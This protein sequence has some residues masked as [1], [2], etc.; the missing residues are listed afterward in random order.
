MKRINWIQLKYSSIPVVSGTSGLVDF[1]IEKERGKL[2]PEIVETITE[3]LRT[4]KPYEEPNIYEAKLQEEKINFTEGTTRN[5]KK[6][7][8]VH[9]TREDVEKVA[10]DYKANHKISEIRQDK[11]DLNVFFFYID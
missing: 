2:T 3:K 11:S 10:Q 8:G 7:V 1:I 5:G 4:A 6:F 9:G